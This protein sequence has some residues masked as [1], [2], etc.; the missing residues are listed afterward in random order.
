M[1]ADKMLYCSFCGES[2]QKVRKLVAGPNVHICDEC[3]GQCSDTIR[4]LPSLPSSTTDTAPTPAEIYKVLNRAIR[5]QGY[6]K[7]LLSIALHRH[8]LRAADTS[9]R[10]ITKTSPAHIFLCGPAMARSE[11]I[12]ALISSTDLPFAIVDTAALIERQDPSEMSQ[13]IVRNLLDATNYHMNE[14]QHV[15]EA[16]HGI[17]YCDDF[18]CLARNAETPS[19]GPK[20]LLQKT[21][22][23][24]MK[25]AVVEVPFSLPNRVLTI[26]TKSV[27]F[28]F[29]G[30]FSDV[31]IAQIRN[32]PIDRTGDDPEL[33]RAEAQFTLS[34]EQAAA[35]TEYGLLPDL[36]DLFGGLVV[37][38]NPAPP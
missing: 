27:T 12:R 6:V 3:I 9:G 29:G 13:L 34:D 15:D 17:V 8:N 18:D 21:L 11:V 31:S 4:E 2:Q 36:V 20:D 33:H 5:G 32:A 16:Q 28:I 35:L 14:A 10:P 19:G 23:G 30:A 24:L 22:I 7:Q 26:D 38:E 25:G 1:S 37:I